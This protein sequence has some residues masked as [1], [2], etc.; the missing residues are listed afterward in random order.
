MPKVKAPAIEPI[1]DLPYT[2]EEI[3]TSITKISKAMET[4]ATSRLT[5]KAIIVLLANTTQ[6]P[7]QTIR[8]V[9]NALHQL[10]SLYL[11]EK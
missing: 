9:L 7:Q 5:E 4:F 11:K 10:E 8:Y 6:L 1:G 2:V 3:V